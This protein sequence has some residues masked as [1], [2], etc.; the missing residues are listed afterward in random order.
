MKKALILSLALLTATPAVFAGSPSNANAVTVNEETKATTLSLVSPELKENPSKKTRKERREIR[1]QIRKELRVKG[2]KS[3]VAALLL[4]FFFGVI[5]VDRFYL[6]YIGLGFLKLF[7]LG[8]LGIWALIDFILI[9]IKKLKP[10][11][12]DYND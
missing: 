4:S 12:G 6:G 5:G 10:K 1:K 3:W 8:G 7:T 2:G 11:D 9:I